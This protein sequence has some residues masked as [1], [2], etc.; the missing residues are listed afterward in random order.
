MKSADGL[1]LYGAVTGSGPV[2]VVLAHGWT[3]DSTCW[4][5]VA[6][7]LDG[8]RVLRYDHRGHGRSAAVDPSTMTIEQLAD[9][10]A[11]VLTAEVPD[12]PIVLVGHS[13]GGMTAMAL[14]ERHPAL[15][16]RVVGLALVA[17]AA[18]EL[19]ATFPEW[20]RTVNERP[21]FASAVWTGRHA[22]ARHPAVLEPAMRA[23]LVGRHPSR[24]ALRKTSEVIAAC[25]PTTLSGFWTTLGAHQR[26]A[27][28]ATYADIPVHV[29]VGTHDRLTPPRYSRRIREA[30]P[31]A[32]FTL[33]PDAGHMLPLERTDGVVSRLQ[34]LVG[35][36][37][38]A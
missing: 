17:T 1:E 8:V 25:R 26:Q 27:A 31:H 36:A 37:V 33:F 6:S 14:A 7:R 24:A 38:P 32:E 29:M 5:P 35:A 18:G 34:A 20:L 21:F 30:L 13:M 12:G 15:A 9:D 28:L 4:E 16:A 22:L 3:L 19:G 10:M 11:A 23:M 2:T